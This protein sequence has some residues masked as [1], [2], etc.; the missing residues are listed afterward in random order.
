[1]PLKDKL[2]LGPITKYQLYSNYQHT[3]AITTI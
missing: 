3:K 1:M 2:A